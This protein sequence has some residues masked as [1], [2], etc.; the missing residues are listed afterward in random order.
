MDTLEKLLDEW[1]KDSDI[2]STEPGKEQLKIPK[3]HSKYLRTLSTTR[4]KLKQLRN[5]LAEMRKIKWQYYNGHLNSNQEML[6]KLGL[7][8]FKFILKADI[9]IYMDSD[10]DLIEITNKIT[11]Y[12]EMTKTIETIL[13]ELKNRV[14]ELKSYIE[15]ERFIAGV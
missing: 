11:Y 4:L 14:W 2:N 6:D 7:E 5:N 3:L 10:K 1:G 8:K 12:E 9:G 13:Q 15:W